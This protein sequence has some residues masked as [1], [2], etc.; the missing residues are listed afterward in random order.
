MI[1]IDNDGSELAY[2]GLFS[3]LIKKI[4]NNLFFKNIL[5]IFA[6]NCNKIWKFGKI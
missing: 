6:I 1:R 4:R 3:D 2:D 5:Y